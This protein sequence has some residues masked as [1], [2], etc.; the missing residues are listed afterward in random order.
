MAVLPQDTAVPCTP[1]NETSHLP[2]HQYTAVQVWIRISSLD[3]IETDR[4]RLGIQS[5]KV[6]FE[7]NMQNL[8]ICRV[9]L[10]QQALLASGLAEVDE[11][12]STVPPNVMK[13]SEQVQNLTIRQE[14]VDGLDSYESCFQG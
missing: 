11:V 10:V 2:V 3:I 5:N 8:L 14:V 7:T 4:V 6:P 12:Q 9:T 1:P 13:G